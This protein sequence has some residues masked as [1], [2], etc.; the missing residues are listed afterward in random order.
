MAVEDGKYGKAVLN[1]CATKILLSMKEQD[2]QSVQDLIGLNDREVQPLSKFKAGQALMINSDA[3]I[4]LKFM[5]SET[6]KLLIFTD[7]ETREKYVRLK[8]EEEA[9][10][11][12][13][14]VQNESIFDDESQDNVIEEELLDFAEFFGENQQ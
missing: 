5:P 9:N 13:R 1:N 8:L 14:E 2:I 10:D 7:K 11:G 6:E 4:A 12:I 3:T